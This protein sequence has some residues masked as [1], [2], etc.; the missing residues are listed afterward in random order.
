M[1][2]MQPVSELE[3]DLGALEQNVRAFRRVLAPRTEL[4]A[5]VK[6]D[7]YGLGAGPVTRRLESV[8]VRWFAVYNLPQAEAAL[9]AGLRGELLV[10]MPAD[11]LPAEG[12]VID[13]AR[14]GRLHLAVHG[15]EQVAS[16]E[17]SVGVLRLKLPVH[18]EVDTGMRR[19]GQLPAE[20]EQLV[21]RVRSSRSLALRGIFTHA[22]SADEEG[23]TTDEQ[24]T[25]FQSVVRRA[26]PDDA[27]V[28][29]HFANTWATIA[30]PRYHQSMVRVGLGLWG[31]PS[32][33]TWEVAR[34]AGVELKPV[35][36]W[37]SRVAHAKTVPAGVSVGYNQ[38]FHTKR[39]SR[40]GIVPVGYADGYPLLLSNKGVVRVGG[41]RVPVPVLGRVNM[42]Q[43]IVDLTDAP[44]VEI[45]AEAEL[46]SNDP[47]APNAMH[48]L[49]ALAQSH[50]YEMLCRISTRVPRKYVG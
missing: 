21:A 6:A 47:G 25:E 24:L 3:V 18:V 32:A 33:G 22:S 35:A 49:A 27:G 4:C 8:G 16:I 1:G 17:R 12:A 9:G 19:G 20:A 34:K 45:G 41:E 50:P 5:V 48:R 26:C 44:G 43:L 31:Y 29:V 38:T 46:I 7:A 23:A 30:G 13:A 42:D 10:L 15:M 11:G 2:V 40:L 14:D 37:V 28:I 39:P 36:R